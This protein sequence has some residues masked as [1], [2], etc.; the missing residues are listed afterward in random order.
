MVSAPKLVIKTRIIEFIAYLR[1]SDFQVSLENTILIGKTLERLSFPDPILS[2]AVCRSICCQTKSHWDQFDSL[3]DNFWFKPLS[4]SAESSTYS[5][6]EADSETEIPTSKGQ[7]A[8]TGL[9]TGTNSP[10]SYQPNTDHSPTG[11]GRQTTVG[12]AD[13]R[14][15]KNAEA[16]R[17]IEVL[18][19][20][21]AKRIRPRVS[22]RRKVSKKAGRI[23]IGPTLK[24]SI[25]TGGSP[26][27]PKFSS[28]KLDPPHLIILHDVSHSMT[29]N[30]PLLFRFTRGLVRHFN[31]A[32]AFVFHM[33]LYRVTPI[34]RESSVG[35]MQERLEQNNRMWFGGTCIADSLGE[36]REKHAKKIIKSDSVVIIVSDGIDTNESIQL[37]DEL[38]FLKRRCR[39]VFWLNPMLERPGFNANKESVLNIKKNVDLLLPAH[40][41]DA[42]QRC[43]KALMKQ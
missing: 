3:F 17:R 27:S 26:M 13:F 38:T 5:T 2:K 29:F 22:R 28:R 36:F 14:F 10:D 19:E 1:K 9:S 34:L 25:R 42:L 12:K 18:A 15:L 43:T 41:L 4:S 32:E 33:R 11:A 40:S 30:N 24:A 35:R 31:D 7:Q 39:R 6:N 37:N 23:S 16:M 21:L 20:R 8:L